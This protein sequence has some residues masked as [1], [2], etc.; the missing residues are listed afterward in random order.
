MKLSYG[1]WD[2]GYEAFQQSPRLS[3]QKLNARFGVWEEGQGYSLEDAPM[4][5]KVA[6]MRIR[7]LMVGQSCTAPPCCTLRTRPI[8]AV[9]IMIAQIDRLYDMHLTVDSDS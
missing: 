4:I 5:C 6:T 8:S 3:L 1:N 2:M 9:H 7:M